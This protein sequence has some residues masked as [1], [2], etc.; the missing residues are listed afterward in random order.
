[1]VFKKTDIAD[2]DLK[3]LVAFEAVLTQRSVT[4]AADRIGLS[5]PA[6][7]TCL[8][9]LRKVLNDPLFV[10]TSRGMEPTP[11]ATELAEPIRHALHLIRQTLNRDKHFDAAT[12]T[13][14]FRI[15]MTDIGER[16]FL[17]ALLQRLSEIA[18][19]VNL[20]TVQLPMKEM[21]AALE[22]GEMDLAVGFIP[23]LAAG[24]YQQR[25]YNRSYVCVARSDHPAI[26]RTLSLKQYLAASHAIVSAPGT[27]H[28]V[29][30]RVL[31]EKGYTR[32]VALHVTHFLAIP[33]IVANTDLVVTIPTMLAESYLPTSNIKLLTPPLK[34]PVYAIKQYWHERFHEDPANRW[35]REL[36]SQLFTD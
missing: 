3:L 6:M 27:G 24:Y 22:S 36:F 18:P 32:R 9:K 4:S 8:G 11:F 30:E 5:Q 33:L 15:I 17:P 10:R 2:L 14:T 35:L 21:R 28:D 29:V 34:M 25:L 26:G 12:S 7:S 31:S 16:V 19:G 13:R 23:D 20:H 1:M